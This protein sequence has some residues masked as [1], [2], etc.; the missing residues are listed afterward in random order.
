MFKIKSRA[1]L[2]EFLRT[3]CGY[4]GKAE[5]AAVKA[6]WDDPANAIEVTGA[7]KVKIDGKGLDALWAITPKAAVE[8]DDSDLPNDDD[9]GKK[10]L[11]D[12]E[13]ETPRGKAATRRKAVAGASKT[14]G[15]T[16]TVSGL[17]RSA[18][19]YARE[20][21]R[22]A[23]NR[24]AASGRFATAF[25]DADMAEQYG[26]WFRR[27]VLPSALNYK[28]KAFDGDICQKANVTYDQSLGGAT[29]PEEF[30][31]MMIDL[32]EQ[33]G[34]ARQL[35]GTTPMARDTLTLPRRTGGNTVYAPGEATAITESNP[36]TD[37]V[38][39]V[40]VK[41]ACYT[42]CSSELLNDSAIN[43][44]DFIAREMAYAFSVK[45]DDCWLTG[46]A[47]SAD[48][49]VNG[50]TTKFL[51][52]TAT[53][54]DIAGLFVA[55]DNNMSLMTVGDL[56]ST[57]ALAP[58]YVD[59][60]GPVW[61]CHK[62]F[63]Y[64]VMRRLILAQGGSTSTEIVNGVPRQMFEGYPVYTT[65]HMTRVDASTDLIC[66]FFGLPRWASKFGE[67]RGGT[68]VAMS[69]HFKFSSDSIAFRAT[70]RVAIN[71]HDIGNSSATDS[72]RVP[73]PLV[74]LLGKAS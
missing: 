37:N 45:E 19:S 1:S 70:Q 52:L 23:Y 74:G 39:L 15:V 13:D 6:F 29:S 18:G 12:D 51:G 55:S 58:N 66:A 7:D 46:D 11:A 27:S 56:I 43:F 62:R 26:A 48:F 24:K 2:M 14:A 67:V 34:L 22:K 3:Q 72:S 10:A 57:M 71:N 69:E 20:A 41:M 17:E 8:D 38:N 31:P 61:I 21:A 54:A 50:L 60:Q 49:N 5:L 16:A 9:E 36:T 53:R 47:T 64:N 4:G 44:G 25:P 63:Y 28:D 33:Y 30:D 42:E 73:G 68:T 40:A 59:A 35:L 65:P 32:K